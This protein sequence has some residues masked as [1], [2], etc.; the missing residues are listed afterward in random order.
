MNYKVTVTCKEGNKETVTI[1]FSDVL[2]R[3]SENFVCFA[4]NDRPSTDVFISV[5]SILRIVVEGIK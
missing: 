1:F 3:F 5:W 2:P 4:Y